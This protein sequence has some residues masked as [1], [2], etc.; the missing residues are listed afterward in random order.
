MKYVTSIQKMGSAE[1]YLCV[2]FSEIL[3]GWNSVI[4]NPLDMQFNFFVC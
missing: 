3:N 1:M 2:L 4:V